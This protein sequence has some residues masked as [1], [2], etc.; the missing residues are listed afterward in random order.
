MSAVLFLC[1]MPW[2][3]RAAGSSPALLLIYNNCFLSKAFNLSQGLVYFLFFFLH[4]IIKRIC[5]LIWP[6]QTHPTM[7]SQT[8]SHWD[9]LSLLLRRTFFLWKN[10]KNW[11]PQCILQFW[12]T[13]KS[14]EF[15]IQA[16]QNKLFLILLIC[17]QKTPCRF[18]NFLCEHLAASIGFF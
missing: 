2:G 17:R 12:L 16:K 5:E 18:Q 10:C 11:Q 7:P 8:N 14:L 3:C 6:K 4:C 9:Q 15:Y 1:R 13:L